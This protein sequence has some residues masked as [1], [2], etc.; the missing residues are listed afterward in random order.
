MVKSNTILILIV[1]VLLGIIAYKVAFPTG[2]TIK[3]IL[4]PKLSISGVSYDSSF[5]L[6]KGCYTKVTGYVS[7]QGNADAQGV[8]VSCTLVGSGGNNFD[9]K[10]IGSINSGGNSYFSLT[11]NNDCPSPDDVRC[12]ASCSNC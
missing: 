9:S 12:T 4:E 7:N 11:I 3:K 2:M 6:T 1:M 5:G 8:V 10:N